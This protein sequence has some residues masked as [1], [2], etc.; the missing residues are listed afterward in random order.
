VYGN[1]VDLR[2]YYDARCKL[3][4]PAHR[5]GHSRIHRSNR[6]QHVAVPFGPQLRAMHACSDGTKGIEK[7]I[8]VHNLAP[9]D[10]CQRAT[11]GNA[12]PSKQGREI[13]R[14]CDQ[15]GRWSNVNQR[16]IQ[17][18][19]NSPFRWV[20]DHHCHSLAG[21]KASASQLGLDNS[22]PEAALA[23][24]MSWRRKG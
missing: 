11:Q 20:L 7:T 21:K 2:F 17:I 15:P 24:P 23:S 1:R 10:D 3:T 12:Q 5:S 22:V 13:G 19:E 18:Q 6:Q 14:D 4:Q 16:S 8:D 9:R